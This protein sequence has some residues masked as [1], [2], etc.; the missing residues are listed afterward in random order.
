MSNTLSF[1]APLITQAVSNYIQSSPADDGG[2]S[3]DP[4][5]SRSQAITQLYNTF[6]PLVGL[7]SSN[8]QANMAVA[9]QPTPY[10]TSGIP[11]NV[12]SYPMAQFQSGDLARMQNFSNNATAVYYD[13]T[14]GVEVRDHRHPVSDSGS[15][16]VEVRDHR[17]PV[18]Q[19]LPP[20]APPDTTGGTG[21]TSAADYGKLND[22]NTSYQQAK[23]NALDNPD[24]PAAQLAF[25]EAAQKLQLLVNT[26]LQSSQMFASMADKAIGNSQVRPA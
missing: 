26:L 12:Q 25:Q 2:S 9:G 4:S 14:R 11:A 6:G 13:N 16:G 5:T 8:Q 20:T 24:D 1:A 23:Q 15:G 3:V 22:A 17:H 19:P 10:S 7:E 18:P 21:F